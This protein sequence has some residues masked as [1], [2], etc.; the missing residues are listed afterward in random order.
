MSKKT[1]HP[2]YYSGVVNA[3]EARGVGGLREVTGMHRGKDRKK[4]TRADKKR[5]TSG[6][7][8]TDAD[9]GADADAGPDN[10]AN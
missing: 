8:D 10:D 6:Q 1:P 2:E 3:N 5:R 9:A 4:I 7:L